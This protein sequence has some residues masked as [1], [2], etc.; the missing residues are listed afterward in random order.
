MPVRIYWAVALLLG[1]LAVG[2]Y[3]KP[4]QLFSYNIKHGRGMDKALDVSRSGKIIAE[5]QADLVALQ[6]VDNQCT[7]SKSIDEAKALGEQVGMHHAF[8]KFM[9]FQGGEYGMAVLSRFPIKETHRHVLPAG[10]EP[11]CALEVVVRPTDWETDLSFICIHNDWTNPDFR[12]AQINALI[13]ALADRAHP[14]V[15]AGDFNGPRDDPSLQLL[16]KEGWTLVEKQGA[17]NTFPS[18]QPRT[19]I[20]F[21]AVRGFAGK[22]GACTVVDER[23]VSDHRPIKMTIT[24]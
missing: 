12:V 8:G 9:D 11:R 14:V 18:V 2:V 5:H 1:C 3:A 13:K 4:V 10:A 15:L 6:E 7:R 23:V 19:E 16:V 21:F 17:K 22:L 20:D 24:P